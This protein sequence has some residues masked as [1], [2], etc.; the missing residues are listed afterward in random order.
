MSRPRLEFT[1]VTLFLGILPTG[2]ETL[3]GYIEG[4][5][6]PMVAADEPRYQMLLERAQSLSDATG[7]V[8]KAVR[9]KK[10]EERCVIRARSA[11]RDKSVTTIMVLPEE[12]QEDLLKVN[13]SSSG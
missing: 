5:Y 3:L 12:V 10:V 6:R 9:F 1:D 4:T 11:M 8:V 13:K 7:I 2:D